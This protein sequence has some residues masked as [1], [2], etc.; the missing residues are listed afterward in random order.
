M[1]L[2]TSFLSSKPS[3]GRLQVLTMATRPFMA[4]LCYLTLVKLLEGPW[5]CHSYPQAW[6]AAPLVASWP[7]PS[8]PS[9]LSSAVTL[10]LQTFLTH[11][12]KAEPSPGIPSF[13][14]PTAVFRLVYCWSPAH[15]ASDPW[16]QE[17]WNCCVC[18]CLSCP[19]NSWCSENICGMNKNIYCHD[20]P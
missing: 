15:E 10:S 16:G 17:L 4:S 2:S 7:T 8:L 14:K 5:G 13:P 11:S 20:L 6:H 9:P 1:S 12:S 19:Y 18:F 3:K